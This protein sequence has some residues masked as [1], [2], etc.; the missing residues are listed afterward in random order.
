M[1]EG[2]VRGADEVEGAGA[3]EGA[4]EGADEGEGVGAGA[5]EVEVVARARA[6]ARARSRSRAR[7]ILIENRTISTATLGC[8]FVLISTWTFIQSNHAINHWFSF[9]QLRNAS[10]N[11]AKNPSAH[12]T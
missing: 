2:E 8:M 9:G 6:W 12:P 3:G 11:S 1:E 7:I 5:G 10:K 4:D